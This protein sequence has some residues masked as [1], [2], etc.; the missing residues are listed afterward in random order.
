MMFTQMDQFCAETPGIPPPSPILIADDDFR[1]RKI[2]RLFLEGYG[3]CCLEAKNGK[4]ALEMIRTSSI[5]VLIT[6]FHMPYMNGCE[7]L[8][9]L[10]PYCLAR[11][12]G[13]LDYRR[14]D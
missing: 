11:A 8:E 3:Y 7:L 9:Q 10:S 4:T 1:C 2:L 14:S 13:C 5:G 6:D 12:P